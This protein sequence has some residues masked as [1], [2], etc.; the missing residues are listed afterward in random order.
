MLNGLYWICSNISVRVYFVNSSDRA[1]QAGWHLSQFCHKK[2]ILGTSRYLTTLQLIG[3]AA[4]FKFESKFE[5]LQVIWQ[6]VQKA[7]PE[8]ED[9][10]KF[11][12][13]NQWPSFQLLRQS[14]HTAW[15]V[16]TGSTNIGCSRCWQ[17]AALLRN[18]NYPSGCTDIVWKSKRFECL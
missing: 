1:R 9:N 16:L 4:E 18:T 13:Q 11:W 17:Q 15:K 7:I 14:S 5:P 2:R 12:L 10:P 6:S 8:L 3:Q